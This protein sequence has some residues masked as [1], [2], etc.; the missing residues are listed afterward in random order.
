M[1]VKGVGAFPAASRPQVIW[2]GAETPGVLKELVERLEERLEP[3]GIP[4]EERAFKS[5]LTLGR[6]KGPKGKERLQKAIEQMSDRIFGEVQVEEVLLMQSELS[7]DGPTY[8]PL[9]RAPLAQ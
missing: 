2:V 4:R 7:P 5:H 1:T 9:H 6:A 8:T 3:L